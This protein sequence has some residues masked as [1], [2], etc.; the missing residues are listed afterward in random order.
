MLEEDSPFESKWKEFVFRVTTEPFKGKR[1]ALLR[2]FF[3]TTLPTINQ[4]T[5]SSL[6][7]EKDSPPQN[8]SP[9]QSPTTR[10]RT[11]DKSV[12]TLN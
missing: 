10:Q 7:K 6:K 12:C 3:N 1:M 4:A 9:P 11:Q 8:H 2:E 5:T